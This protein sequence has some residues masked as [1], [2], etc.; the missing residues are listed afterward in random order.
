[1][2]IQATALTG[3]HLSRDGSVFFPAV[4]IKYLTGAAL[5]EER[6]LGL[7]IQVEPKQEL[8]ERVTSTRK[9]LLVSEVS[10]IYKIASYLKKNIKWEVFLIFQVLGFCLC[11]LW[12]KH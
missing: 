12:L 6:V 3:Y 5:K 11:S 8:E 1:M 7:S 9:S 4:M 10:G 2:D